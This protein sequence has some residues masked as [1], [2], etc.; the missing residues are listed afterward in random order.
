MNK[1]YLIYF[2]IILTK[3]YNRIMKQKK[4][5]LKNN[6]FKKYNLPD[7]IDRA[8][9]EEEFNFKLISN[10]R[11]YKLT[12]KIEKTIKK[13]KNG[14]FGYCEWCFE[15]INIKRLKAR[16]IAKLCIDCKKMSEKLKK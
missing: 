2:E 1:N 15:K 10:E 14:K 16:P 9:Q 5:N 12:K 3:W 13:I 4:Y 11:E 7:I 8:S 6:Y